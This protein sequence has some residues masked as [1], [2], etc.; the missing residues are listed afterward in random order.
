MIVRFGRSA[1]GGIV[2]KRCGR[3]L[4]ASPQRAS[5]HHETS[6]ESNDVDEKRHVAPGPSR[7]SNDA[8]QS[9]R[10]AASAPN[11]SELGHRGSAA[12]ARRSARADRTSAPD[13]AAPNNLKSA[14]SCSSACAQRSHCVLTVLGEHAIAA[15]IARNDSPASRRRI[16]SIRAASPSLHLRSSMSGPPP[17][18]SEVGRTP[19]PPRRT[20]QLPNT[21]ASVQQVRGQDI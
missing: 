14:R 3:S 13:G 20:G 17:R 2:S 4:E 10:S 9:T 8:G 19:Q 21:P 16:I 12:P 11:S 18:R 1:L 15:A 5:D 6:A 7:S